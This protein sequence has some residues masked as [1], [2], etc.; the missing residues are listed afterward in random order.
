[1]DR[2]TTAAM[3][4]ESN[5]SNFFGTRL[6]IPEYCNDKLKQ[7]HVIPQCG[8]FLSNWGKNMFGQNQYPRV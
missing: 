5:L 1:M 4:Q 8:Y 6:V 7:N 2:I 3:W